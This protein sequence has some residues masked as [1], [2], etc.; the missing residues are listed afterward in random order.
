[1]TTET[2]DT[3]TGEILSGTAL[4]ASH[5]PVNPLAALLAKVGATGIKQVTR[6]VLQQVD[7]VPIAVTFEGAAYEGE[8]LQAGKGS[9][10]KMAPARLANIINL[11]TGEKQSLIMNTVLEGELVRNFGKPVG[12][13]EKGEGATGAYVGRS[14]VI[15][16]QK[17]VGADGKEKRYRVYQIAE[18]EFEGA[19]SAE[20]VK[21]A[22]VVATGEEPVSRDGKSKP[23]G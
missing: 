7:G 2:I 16:S 8:E 23:K 9:G 22:E 13:N 19:A 6:S 11:E 21:S 17:P 1:M 15:G 12:G 14:F 20:N 10:T 4:A 5:A 18:L 3:H